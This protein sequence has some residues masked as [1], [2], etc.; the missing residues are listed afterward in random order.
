MVN[1]FFSYSVVSLDGGKVFFNF[2]RI[3]STGGCQE[4]GDEEGAEGFF[5]GAVQGEGG[6]L[7]DQSKGRV[8]L[9]KPGK[10]FAPF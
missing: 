4:D 5:G 9:Q 2:F 3:V 8:R 7:P 1:H 10:C 6:T